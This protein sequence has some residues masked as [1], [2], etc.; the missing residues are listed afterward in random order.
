MTRDGATAIDS[1][2]PQSPND[3]NRKHP[4]GQDRRADARGIAQSDRPGVTLAPVI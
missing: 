2:R 4:N 3:S 1:M